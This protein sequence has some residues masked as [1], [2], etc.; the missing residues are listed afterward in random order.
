MLPN[1]LLEYLKQKHWTFY[2]IALRWTD[3]GSL[4]WK[5]LIIILSGAKT[6]ELYNVNASI[7]CRWWRSV[8]GTIVGWRQRLVQIVSSAKGRRSHHVQYHS[9]NHENH[10]HEEIIPDALVRTVGQIDA[11]VVC[12]VR[13]AIAK[14]RQQ[15]THR[16]LVA[17]D[18]LTSI[19]FVTHDDDVADCSSVSNRKK[20]KLQ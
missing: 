6:N 12:A 3:E 4:L 10:H 20:G 1:L 17:P 2:K 15:S 16:N 14:Q 11:L 5:S 18:A 9:E 8:V 13:L 7:D 19:E